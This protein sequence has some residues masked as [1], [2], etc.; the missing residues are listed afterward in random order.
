[1]KSRLLWL[2]CLMTGAMFLSPDVAAR[3][4]APHS[5]SAEANYSAVTVGWKA[6]DAK[7]ELKLH[8]DNDYDGDSGV[9]TSSQHPCVIYVA[10]EF[11][12]SD[13]TLL[14]GEKIVSLNYFEYRP[15]LR[16]TAM[17]WEDGVLVREVDA[18]LAVPAFEKNQWRTVTFAEPYQIVKGK[19]VRI[20]FRIE[21]GTNIDFVAIMDRSH[22]S[23]GDLRSYDG[24]NWVHNGRGTY[25]VTANLLNETD[26][27][28]DGYNV[29]A[30]GKKAN[31]ALL[32]GSSLMLPAQTDGVH[33]YKVEAVYGTQSYFT[34]EV[35]VTVKSAGMYFPSVGAA[36]AVT[37][38]MKGTLH[39]KA[40]LLKGEGN[41]LSWSDSKYNSAIGGTASSNTKVWIKNEFEP[42]DL[43]AFAGSRITAINAHF[44]EK[45][46]KSMIVFVM[47]DGVIA[48]YDS[49]PETKIAEISADAWVK[50]PLSTP[51]E[52][53]PGH[54][55]SYGY[56]LIHT[57]KTHPVST[58]K[59]EAMGSKANSFSTSSSNSKDFATSKPSWKTLASGGL[60]G[61]W[62]LTADVEGTV[63]SYGSVASYNVWRDGEKVASAL[64]TTEWEDEVPAPGVYT[65]GIEAVGSDGKSS[66]L[67]TVKATYKLPDSYRAPL[68]GSSKLDKETQ[69]V[70][71]DWGMDVELKHYGS[72]TY[73]VGFDE[74][75][76][77][78]YGSRFTATELADYEGY[79][80]RKLNFILGEDIPAGFKLEIINGEGKT[81][82][83]QE[84]APNTVQPLAMYSLELD[85]PVTITGKEDLILAYTATL[86]GKTSPIV[87]DAGPLVT[88]G[89]VVKLPGMSWINLGTINATYNNYNIV[90]G[91]VVSENESESA[92]QRI[93]SRNSDELAHAFE[94]PSINAVGAAD[95]FGIG[96]LKAP[97]EPQKRALKPTTYNVYRNGELALSTSDRSFSEKLPS[98]DTWTYTVTAVYPNG[99]ESAESDPLII[100]NPVNQAGPAPYD[101]RGDFNSLTWKAPETAPV[102][103]YAKNGKSFGV[104]MTGSGTRETFAVHKYPVDS[105]KNAVGQRIS[106]IRF[107]LLSTEL[108]SAS[109]VILKNF[110]IV[111]EQPVAVSDLVTVTDGYNEI[112]LNQ[113][114]EIDGKGELMIGYH[115]TYANGI[116]PMIFDEG[117]ADDGLGNLLSASA[118]QTSWKT[119]KSLNK[120]LDGNWR[121]YA[122]LETPDIHT[123][124]KMRRSSDART[125]NI[126]R[127]GTLFKS[128]LTSESYSQ[129]TSLSGGRYTVTAVTG[130]VESAPSNEY[131]LDNSGI[132]S[133]GMGSDGA[134]Y[135]A[136]TAT[137]IIPEGHSGTIFD[138]AGRRMMDL[139][140]TV[141]VACLS[142]GVYIY[143]DADGSTLRFVR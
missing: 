10:S 13:L 38:A 99:W 72:A 110:N 141:S 75:M 70:S 7:K 135:D 106:H 19:T 28:P 97:S 80:I 138:A 4:G 134:R 33:L 14:E 18:N 131:Y 41:T 56:Y 95:G 48:H 88:G 37:D 26:E 105:L 119:L 107:A 25:L 29:Y 84:I 30:D 73:K 113:P 77:L 50:I 111:Y 64:K 90:I 103:T 74:D 39:W 62:M 68:I 114:Y 132:E 55:Y 142:A 125:Y 24:K 91:A 8:N 122:V 1:M 49:V 116:K 27:A 65:Y 124:M 86:P 11:S 104:G 69:T 57:P 109:I 35:P 12:P 87:L 81:V 117:P 9:Q 85:A 32:S 61:G 46:A 133:I 59:T 123:V 78:S 130:D 137:M 143:V 45:E 22:D 71:F 101:L 47:K 93:L 58:D 127:D 15:T 121:I 21:H 102:L 23:R 100:E 94:L 79:T 89:A 16:V 40:P 92:P 108:N 63:A 34:P 67:Y 136:A 120:D 42:A 51:V 128:G 43:L 76:V 82:A 60:P 98:Y 118:S 6:S 54:S 17:I 53:E 112:R 5:V 36:T 129:E 52:I 66:D 44:H 31:D 115:I 3:Q 126:Y 139:K 96:S 2:P 20:G 140:G 83:S